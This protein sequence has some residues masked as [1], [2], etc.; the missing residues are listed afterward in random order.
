MAEEDQEQQTDPTQVPERDP[1]EA[2]KALREQSAQ[3]REAQ[4]SEGGGE[5]IAVDRLLAQAQ[6]YTGYSRAALV[7]GLRLHDLE[8]RESLTIEEA[9]A[10]AEAY[11]THEVEYDN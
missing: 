3:E 9:R 11:R 4:Q 5:E 8:D 2:T 6:A 10:A 7:G 1:A